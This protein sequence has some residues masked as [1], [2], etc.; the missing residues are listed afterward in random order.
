MNS[1][2]NQVDIIPSIPTSQAYK[3][4]GIQIVLDGNQ[5]EQY[6]KLCEKCNQH[7]AMFAQ[8]QFHPSDIQTR[9]NQVFLHA[10]KYPLAA[11]SLTTLQFE[12]CK[13]MLRQLY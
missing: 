5:K 3:L 7:A 8:N 11:A 4:L 10:I 9:Y 6:K 2:T 13:Q 1:S 12:K